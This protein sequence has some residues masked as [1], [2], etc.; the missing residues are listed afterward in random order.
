[1]SPEVAEAPSQ[2]PDFVGGGRRTWKQ[3]NAATRRSG[4]KGAELYDSCGGR[5]RWLKMF[6]SSHAVP[7]CVVC[8]SPDHD[9]GDLPLCS[10]CCGFDRSSFVET[11]SS[12][13]RL[14]TVRREMGFK[15]RRERVC[16]KMNLWPGRS[17]LVVARSGIAASAKRC[18]TD[19]PPLLQGK[20]MQAVSSITGRSWSASSI[21]G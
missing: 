5:A 10:R 1:M 4:S 12:Q 18:K 11:S 2:V 3:V 21:L 13:W 14:I 20:H 9:S 6:G 17:S 16:G 15:R 19:I 7:F 8:L